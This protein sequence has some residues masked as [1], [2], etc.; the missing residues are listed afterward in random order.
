M[1]TRPIDPAK[2]CPKYPKLSKLDCFKKLR[3]WRSFICKYNDRYYHCFDEQN[4]RQ[5]LN[6]ILVLRK[7]IE[8]YEKEINFYNDIIISK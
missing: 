1:S 6:D 8:L 3:G 5:L 7:C 2:V 4:A